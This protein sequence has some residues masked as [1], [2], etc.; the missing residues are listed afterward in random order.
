MQVLFNVNP[1]SYT[2]SCSAASNSDIANNIT[3]PG[4][5]VPSASSLPGIVGAQPALKWHPACY[6]K[7]SLLG[8]TAMLDRLAPQGLLCMAQQ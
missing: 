2:R 5:R 7:S 1:V 8:I 3:P 4:S 6:G